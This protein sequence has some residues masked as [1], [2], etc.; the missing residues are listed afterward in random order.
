[1]HIASI[2]SDPSVPKELSPFS[3]FRF[4]FCFYFDSDFNELPLVR[5]SCRSNILFV[6]GPGLAPGTHPSR[7]GSVTSPRNRQNASESSDSF[8]HEMDFIKTL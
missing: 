7:R 2:A 4:G 8:Y 3:F 6:S 5:N 1:M